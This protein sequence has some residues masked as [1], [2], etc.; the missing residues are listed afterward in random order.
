MRGSTHTLYHRFAGLIL[1]HPFGLLLAAALGLLLSLLLTARHLTFQTN[2]L[3]LISSGNHYRQLDDAYDREFAPLPGDVIVVIRSA[4]PEA[5][6]AF[7]TALAQ[8]WASNPHIEQVLYRINLDALKQKAL[9]Y[10][11]PDEL[12]ALRQTLQTHQAFLEELTAAPTLENLLTL[13]NREMSTALV[14]QVFT[15][16]LEDDHPAKAPPDLSL[17]VALLQQMNRALEAPHVYQSPWASLFARDVETSRQDGF[18]WSDDHHLLF[19][20]VQP[21]REAGEFNRFDT[22]VQQIRA[23]VRELQKA[24]PGVEVGITGKSILDADEMALAARDTGLAT[25]ISVVGVTLLY[26]GLFKGVV[27]PLLALWTLVLGLCWALG[28]TTLTIGHLNILS[29]V[30]MP[31]LLGLGIDY[32]SYFISRYM[33]ERRA[34]KVL[35]EAM[36]ETFVA[37]GPGIMATALTTALTFGTLLLTGFKGLAEL[38]FI[39]GSGILLAALAT[40]TVLPALLALQE[41]RG[42]GWSV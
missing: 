26:F 22:A 31:M 27:R 21:K 11:S 13:I 25:V 32:G 7:A 8:R 16:F 4:R 35:Q 20:L 38:G 9:L 6:T 10:L 30:F 14:G 29:I 18:L 3:D 15:G 39:G 24:H 2:R 37:T 42:H 33:E 34:G 12:M 1:R 28:F 40:F 19:V 17:L 23:D 41:R 36:V 5:A